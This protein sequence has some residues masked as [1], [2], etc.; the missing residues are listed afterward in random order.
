LNIKDFVNMNDIGFYTKM[1]V[2]N[3]IIYHYVI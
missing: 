2:F 3:R 1:F